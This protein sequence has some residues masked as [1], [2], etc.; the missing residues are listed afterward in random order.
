MT[1]SRRLVGLAALTSALVFSACASAGL[2]ATD[3][4]R[5]SRD[6]RLA[7]HVPGQL[8]VGLRGDVSVVSA[9]DLHRS[10]VGA[11]GIQRLGG[12]VHL[13]KLP[14]GLSLAK[15]IARYESDS[16][17]RYAEPNF[18]RER[19]VPPPNDTFFG[20][21]WGLNNTGQSHGMSDVT[22][23]GSITGTNDADMDVLAAWDNT[24]A[25]NANT[26]VAVIDDGVMVNHQ[27][28]AG[29]M[30]V[31]PGE[32]GGGKETNGLDDDANGRIDDV[33]GWDFVHNDKGLLA[34]PGVPGGN[35]HGTHV[36]GTIAAN[37]N[38]S[39]GISGVCPSCRIMG[40]KVM[41]DTTG[42][43]HDAAIIAAIN[44]ATMKG[45]KVANMSFGGPGFGVS[46]RNA[47]KS[48]PFLSVIAAGNSSTDN[49][50]ALFTPSGNP[51]S[52]S[53]PASH[54]LPNILAVAASNH[55]D[56]FGYDTGCHE[57]V[58]D[59]KNEC[60]FTS[61]GH[62]SV[63]VAAPGVDIASTV[64]GCS[65]PGCLQASPAY[66]L[67]NGTSMAAPNTAGVAG[68][69][70][71]ARPGLNAVQTKNAI[72]R[73][74]DKPASLSTLISSR[75]K[76]PIPNG[77]YIR[78]NGRVNA[79]N[80]LT[81]G[82]ANATTQTDGNIDGAR[83]LSGALRTAATTAV[84][85]GSVRW[86]SDINDVYKRRL[87]RGRYRVTL[88]VPAGKDYDL[89]AYRPGTLEIWQVSKLAEASAGG[90][91]VDEGD[92]FRVRRAA[93]W[94]FQV[95]A[96]LRNAGNYTLRLRKL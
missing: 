16:R 15:A 79:N 47:I 70:R 55:R 53:F 17:V 62:D 35:T 49:D 65:G 44:Y 80:A 81:A 5:F 13:V 51:V 87:A 64:T 36:A 59:T 56:E 68:L 39:A 67:F 91:G 27:D 2:V 41:H 6:V 82:A 4:Q 60:A 46:L 73:G 12:K 58:G 90:N 33:N 19:Y 83:L 72:M 20:Q 11:R 50:M 37:D 42:N 92:T 94:Y 1:Q 3:I 43:L 32:S 21:L 54:T 25:L 45:A 78:T 18:L 52:P 76:N 95:S 89:F 26:I 85:R 93:T 75:F 69:V 61:W 71:G 38:N 31:N 28:L 86:A 8:L 96:W 30:W 24:A 74:T 22:G 23:G 66:Q 88:I 48:A 77:S 40:L 34:P 29:Q 57:L 7:P 10:T 9:R 63:D 14:K 84:K